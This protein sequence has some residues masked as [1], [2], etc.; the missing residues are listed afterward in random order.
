MNSSVKPKISITAVL[1]LFKEIAEIPRTS[2]N[3]QKIGEW[4][5]NW[6]NSHNFETDQD[7]YGNVLIRIP[8]TKGFEN[9]APIALQVHMDMVGQKSKESKHDFLTEPIQPYVDG[10]W[11][12][13]RGGT[14]LG[15][16]N[17][18]GLAMSLALA[19][20]SEV[21]HPML[22]IL[23][24]TDEE[25]GLTGAQGITPNWLKSLQLVNLD[26]EDDTN[27]TI[28]CAG[29][30]DTTIKKQY[31]VHD[32][33]MNDHQIM[34]ISISNGQGGH[35]G[36]EIH[37][38][39][40][41][42]N[43]ILARVLRYLAVSLGQE[44]YQLV[45]INGGTVR[46]GISSD[47]S[48]EITVNSGLV[49]Q[50]KALISDY[51]KAIFTP[52][53]SD[54]EPKMKIEAGVSGVKPH[55]Q[56]VTVEDTANIVDTMLVIPHGV[57]GMSNQVS[58]LVETS[59]NFAIAKLDKGLLELTCMHRSSVESRLK[60]VECRLRALASIMHATFEL[61]NHSPSWTPDPD[62][63]LLK[64]VAS[65]YEQ[66]FGVKPVIEAIHAGLEC[67]VIGQKHPGME[68]VSIGPKIEGAHTPEERLF[69]P[70]V[71]KVMAWLEK[72]VGE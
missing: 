19:E 4:L 46:N 26:S 37:K 55:V 38:K 11:L 49:A 18:I 16:D 6:G 57:L 51:F 5:V 17:G 63:Y 72:V 2:K 35:S 44:S 1:N 40:A 60:E 70:S 34:E 43:I 15:A 9:S 68:M 12:K 69:I 31:G 42:A 39:I 65:K 64:S 25:T 61:G 14:T 7:N 28:G 20:S 22:E 56:A 66:L 71:G 50:V 21:N 48:C 29:S 8:A 27:I 62:N 45:S 54:C 67:G 59:N 58:G 13:A 24:T 33:N 36:V 53:Y 47:C 41:N 52:E 3:E 10:E 23:V 32:I 30:G